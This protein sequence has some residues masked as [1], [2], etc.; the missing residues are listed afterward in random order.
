MACAPSPSADATKEG[1]PSES[2]ST[3]P[4]DSGTHERSLALVINEVMPSNDS[5][6]LDE[7]GLASDWVEL[8]NTTDASIPWSSVRITD[9]SE[10]AW[11]GGEGSIGPGERV[12]LGRGD[13]GF[14]LDA[15]GDSLWVW[16]DDLLSDELAWE[17]V[18]SDVSLARIPDATGPW[19]ETAWPT[20][21]E[22][23]GEV[24]PS[25]DPADA[26]VFV[27]DRV[28]TIDFEV[29]KEAY[30]LLAEGSGFIG[31]FID[32][33]E[34]EA[35]M[36]IDGIRFESVGLRRKGSASTDPLAGKPPFKVDMNEFVSGQK[37]RSLKGFNL[38]NG[39]VNDP[40]LVHEYLSY[41]LA[42]ES[43]MAAPRVGWAV[44]SLNG[45]DYG[46]YALVEQHDDVFVE[47]N[48]PGA[49]EQGVVL[50]PNESGDGSWLAV[51]DFG[52][53]QLDW[54]FEEGDVPVDPEMIASVESVNQL[55]KGPATDEAVAEL[56]EVAERDA[57]LAYFAWENVIGHTDG[58]HV[59]N[60]W[61]LYVDPDTKR[62]QLLPSGADWTWDQPADPWFWGG[63]LADWC[64]SNAGCEAG[65]AEK[66]VEVADTTE[67]IDLS[68]D[69]DRIW[70]GIEGL[71]LSQPRPNHPERGILNAHDRTVDNLVD[72]PEDARQAACRQVPSVCP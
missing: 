18:V 42:R 27:S 9:G 36:T 22:E 28:H 68:G 51:G 4:L 72:F 1:T 63:R 5:T 20:P 60:N 8:V 14:G 17:E 56:W 64:L 33:Q 21:G 66:M 58:Y 37:F 70:A 45:L 41:R 34:V 32:Y 43:G 3:V 54:D 57:V 47:R 52:T 38:H 2:S 12:L 23:N 13:L 24:S 30:D 29:T 49:G 11:D 53:N 71:V 19:A 10:G 48:F 67:A 26:T 39:K 31:T 7:A 40:T 44:V 50:E 65:V 55:V 6:W 46:I 25:L 61:R 62:L 15:D 69:F 16:V 59:P 35:V